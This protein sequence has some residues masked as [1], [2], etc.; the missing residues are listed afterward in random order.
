MVNVVS[1]VFTVRATMSENLGLSK[2]KP[3]YAQFLKVALNYD[4]VRARLRGRAQ[5]LS[6][7]NGPHRMPSDVRT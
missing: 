1:L 4:M 5:A 3:L 2:H 7:L 6:G